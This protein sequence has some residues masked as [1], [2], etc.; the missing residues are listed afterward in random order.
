[1][2]HVYVLMEYRTCDEHFNHGVFTTHDKAYDYLE[3]KKWDTYD[4]FA[5]EEFKL[6]EGLG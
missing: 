3:K 4:E 2:K 1:M 5:I 6:D